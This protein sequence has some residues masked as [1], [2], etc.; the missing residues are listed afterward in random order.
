MPA[1][2]EVI[3]NSPLAPEMPLILTSIFPFPMYVKEGVFGIA[4]AYEPLLI[5][6]ALIT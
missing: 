3:V 5:V 2:A 6:L 1:G 4:H